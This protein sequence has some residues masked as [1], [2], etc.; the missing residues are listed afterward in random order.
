MR[1]LKLRMIQKLLLAGI[2]LI[3]PYIFS[4]EPEDYVVEAKKTKR[5]I[6]IDGQF[7]E[8]AWKE[9]ALV[10]KFT[11]REPQEGRPATERT[12]VRILYDEQNLYF[13]IVCFDSEPGKIVANEMRRDAELRDNDYFEIFIDTFNDHRNAFYFVVN[14]LGAQQDA[15]IRDE[16]ASINKNWD[17]I[18][19]VRTQ[20]TEKGWTAEIAI[21]FYTLRFRSE[22]NQTWGINFGRMIARKREESYWTPV[23]RDYGF[24]GQYR[25]SFYGH[26]VG[27]N[28]LRQGKRVQLMPYIIGGGTKPDVSSSFSLTGDLGLDL[29]Y[30]LTSNLTADITLNT[31]FA[32]VEADQEQFN[33]TRFSLYFPEKREFFLEGADIFRFGERYQEHESPSTLLF[34]SRT[35]GLSE[36]EEGEE[37][38][39]EI[40]I[41][42]GIRV[43]GKAGRYDVG[44]LDL[45]TDRLS[46]L[47]N[48]N[49][50]H[51]QRTNYS[52]FRIK[53]DIFEK[54]SI[55]IMALSKDS[56]EGRGSDYN[57]A[58]GFDFNLAFGQSMKAGG[59]L[60]KTFSPDLKRKDWAGYLN[61]IWDSDFFTGDFSYTDIGDNFNPEMGFVPRVD[62]RKFRA[63]IGIGPR[64]QILG[65]RQI[66][67]FNNL[68]YIE[69]HA[70]QLESRNNLIG[71][72]NLFQNGSTL[73]FAY[74]QNYEHL[75]E[76]FEIIEDVLIPTGRYRF[77]MFE[78][79]YE[80]DMT[81][82]IALRSEA[83]YGHFYNGRLFSLQGSGF[84][85]ISRNFNLEFVYSRNQ[86]DLPVR[87]GKFTTNIAGSRII[88]SFTPNLFAKAYIQWNDT[89]NRFI[90]NFLIRWIYKPGANIYFI[91]NETRQL[92]SHGYLEDRA[93]MLK[94]SFLFNY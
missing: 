16:G 73:F 33:L 79:W 75:T 32:Q 6:T 2:L 81:K 25:I 20:R 10:D 52:V 34:F 87:G 35:I 26:L 22:E 31:D 8:V 72:F 65:L 9:A 92:G 3:R 66:F 69:N 82:R 56:L 84:L 60:A 59:F 94:V 45:A 54:S 70:G 29:K 17:G 55:G 13:G 12:E 78:T 14:P 88:Y 68:T 51:L 49:D 37:E 7:K 15:L 50:I 93:L 43:T 62:I 48:G 36:P 23:L 76:D 38:G 47:E 67:L 41:I 18:W 28:H 1:R 63:D 21:P 90:S 83:S 24:F 77:N 58:T 39:K 89:E 80:S 30:R 85:K 61:F 19:I 27:L 44:I 4:L 74:I 86:F 42:G 71:M 64:P 40:P 11:Q 53:R 46:Y 5:Q 91:Y 57:R